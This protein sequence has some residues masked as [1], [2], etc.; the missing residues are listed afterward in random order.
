VCARNLVDHINS[1]GKTAIHIIDVTNP[2]TP[3]LITSWS[4]NLDP[5]T[6]VGCLPNQFAHSARF[7]DGGNS[8]YVSYWDAGTVHLD[9]TNPAAPAV[10]SQTKIIPPSED[11]DN[12]S[13]T[14]AGGGRWL[15]INT[16]DF[17]PSDCPGHSEFGAW[18]SVYIYDNTDPSH[19]AFLGTFSTDDSRSTRTD[20]DYTDHN[21]EVFGGDQ[22]FSSWYSDGIVWWTLNDQGVTHQLGQ[23]VPP[24]TSTSPPEVWGV[25]IDTTHHLILASDITSGLWI[26]KP[27]GLRGF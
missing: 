14:L 2:A 11:G 8:L 9:V 23:F 19:P 6:G 4:L 12:H 22:L 16:E 26:I 24:A 3:Q 17:S 1:G 18:G 25:F 27:E 10:I 5:N 15:V 7:E 13:M 21:T 20:G